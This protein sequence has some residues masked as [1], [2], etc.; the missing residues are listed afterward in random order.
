MFGDYAGNDLEEWC[1]HFKLSTKCLQALRD[2]LEATSVED[3][4]F[5]YS[6]T[7]ML[8]EVET[9][10]SKIEYRR[11]LDA[12][13]HTDKLKTANP[14][15]V[16]AAAEPIPAPVEPSQPFCP[17]M[18]PLPPTSTPT[19]GSLSSMG[20]LTA[21][22][23]LVPALPSRSLQYYAPAVPGYPLPPQLIEQQRMMEAFAEQQRIFEEKQREIERLDRELKE[24]S[25]KKR[26]AHKRNK[27]IE[28]R[29]RKI[30]ELE[31]QIRLAA[32]LDMVF[33]V[34][35]T[36]SMTPY[37]NNV[38]TKIKDFVADIIK[39]HQNVSL[40]LAFVGYRDHYNKEKRLEVL[41][42]TTD[43]NDFYNKLQGVQPISNDDEAED[44]LGG[45][46]IAKGLEWL[47]QTKILYHVGDAPC[48]GREFHTP[49][50]S[51]KN[52]DGCPNGLKADEIIL[53][54][55]QLGVTYYF[56]QIK[57]D[58][59]D[60]MINKFNEYVRNYHLANNNNEA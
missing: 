26:R 57:K 44:V 2:N 18:P 32:S 20:S 16:P 7:D 45:L 46:H 47:S 42:F 8:K 27:L 55:L 39:M 52:L 43:V 1:K 58:Y 38:K 14:D 40:R 23:P 15:P 12:K 10:C 41:R 6:D 59:T 24:K 34:D 21:S 35:C 17:V 53:A 29:S 51:D 33:V 11:F 50:V 5:V 30:R 4:V 13:N 60:L 37:I 48:H 31:E 56:G 9:N 54:I 22:A 36:G 49:K 28:S 25:E 19:M 3:L